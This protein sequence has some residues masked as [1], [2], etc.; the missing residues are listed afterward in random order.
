MEQIYGES[1][2]L[3]GAGLSAGD[4]RGLW[5]D[6]HQTAWALKYMQFLVWA[7]DPGEVL[8]SLKL[9][10]PLMRVGRETSRAGVIGAVFTPR[11]KR[12]AGHARDMVRAVGEHCRERG[13]RLALLFSDIGTPYYTKLGFCPL[14]AEEQWGAIPRRLERPGPDWTIADATEE[15]LPEIMRA[16]ADTTRSREIAIIR[17]EEH[18][19][20]LGVRSSSFF[21]RLDDRTVRQSTLVARRNG[22][23]SGYIVAVCGRGEW[24]VREVGAVEGCAERMATT[25]RLA[26]GLAVDERLRRFYG[27]LPRE[28]V[29]RLGDWRLRDSRRKRAIPMILPLSGPV[30][31]EALDAPG[32]AYMPYQDQF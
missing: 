1:H 3:W 13:D 4:Y 19:G 17:D 9:Y 14:P 26:A 28:V 5:T 2:S 16:H 22:S 6:I 8:S 23:F 21:S 29:D 27:W 20:F 31:L 18:W 7:D 15:D 10:R 12:L 11:K 30:D 25:V 32:P 24:N